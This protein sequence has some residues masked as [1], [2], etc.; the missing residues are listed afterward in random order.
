MPWDGSRIVVAAS[1]G[2]DRVVVAG[3]PTSRW[4]SR[5]SRPTVT[6]RLAFVSDRG[7]WVNVTVAGAR[8]Q[9]ACRVPVA[10]RHEHAEPSWGP[11]QRSFAWSPDG[12]SIAS[13]RNEDGFGRS[14][15][16][17]VDGGPVVEWSRRAGTAGSTGDRTG[18]VA[19]RSGARTPPRSWCSARR[20]TRV[21]RRADRR[22]GARH[23]RRLP[24]DT[25]SNPRP[26]TWRAADGA[27][28]ARPVVSGAGAA[29]TD[30]PSP[31]R[32]STAARPI[33]PASTGT[34]RTQYF[35][36]P[37]VVGAR[38]RTRGVRPATAAAYAQALRGEWGALDV[39]DVIA[40]HPGRRGARVGRS[41]PRRARGRQRRRVHRAARRRGRARARA[42]GRGVVPRDR[43]RRAR[44][45]H[46]PVR[47]PR[48]RRP[49]VGALRPAAAERVPRS[50]A[51]HAHADAH[52]GPDARAAGRRRPGRAG[53]RRSVAFADARARR[54][55]RRRA[56]RVR[57]RE[58]H[59]WWR[60]R[61]PSPM[62]SRRTDA[63]LDA[64][65]CS[66]SDRP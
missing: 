50:V 32:S 18:L 8:R 39:D 58:G 22:S 29:A 27:D 37:G 46:P 17:P 6:A 62:R 3:G 23:R 44:R 54:G 9:P 25:P 2:A 12:R 59:G 48:V 66:T 53:R 33:R 21:R 43:P 52:P 10:E 51:G 65:R 13:C 36:R 60:S 14:V 45:A 24:V 1:D 38:P 20:P 49:L 56:P 19:T 41:P 35:A 7:G 64:G 42:R 28:R 5:A 61:R 47:T 15:V 63:F 34:P 4:A 55:R 11:G 57:R 30:R 31:G 26:V 40:G 16:V